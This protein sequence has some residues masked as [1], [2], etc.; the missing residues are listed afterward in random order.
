MDFKDKTIWITGASSGIGEALAYAYSRKGSK[1]ILSSRKRDQLERVQN[2]CESLGGKAYVEPLDLSELKTLKGKA[3][4][5]LKNYGPID[6]LINN[7]GVAQRSSVVDMDLEVEQKMMRVNFFGHAELTRAVLPDM[8]QRK[9]GHI[10]VISS[11]M[12]K[13]SYPN[14]STYAA[15][16]HALHGYFDALRAEVDPFGIKVTIVCPGFVKTNISLNAMTSDGTPH[17]KMDRGQAGGISPEACAGKIIK[18]INR[19]REEINIGGPE[20]AAVYIKR[21][22]PWIVSRVIKRIK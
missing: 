5:I 21:W 4:Y 6:L 8:V 14:C 18:A 17:A 11:V 19:G 15:S 1:I 13:V 7:G 16:K 2:L 3:D 22:V 20:I 12:G 9:K 10:V